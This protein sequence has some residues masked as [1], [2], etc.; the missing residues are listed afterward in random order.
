M[1][2][3]VREFNTG[4]MEGNAQVTKEGDPVLTLHGCSFIRRESNTN[5][6]GIQ[7]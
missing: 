5:T 7:C 6:K 3:R 2:E 4:F 1:F